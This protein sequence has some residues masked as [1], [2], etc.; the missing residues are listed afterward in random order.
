MRETKEVSEEERER[1]WEMRVRSC[2][3]A[4]M[5][6]RRERCWE[7]RRGAEEE[8]ILDLRATVAARKRVFLN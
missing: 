3:R 5:R 8:S 6:R 2:V 7:S 4:E 1:R